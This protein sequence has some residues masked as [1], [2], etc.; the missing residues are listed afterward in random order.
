MD[1]EALWI[2]TVVDIEEENRF[3]ALGLILVV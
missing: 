3:L 1:L 2:K